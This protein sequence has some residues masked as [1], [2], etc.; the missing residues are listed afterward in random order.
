[1]KTFTLVLFF[2][3]VPKLALSQDR[4]KPTAPPKLV[5]RTLDKML[6]QASR[7]AQEQPQLV[8]KR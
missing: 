4:P 1:M 8:A 3:A 7:A 6:K 5:F 2:A